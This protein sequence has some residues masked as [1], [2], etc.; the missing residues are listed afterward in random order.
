MK[1]LIFTFGVLLF[2]GYSFF[3]MDATGL[4]SAEGLNYVP[5]YTSPSPEAASL[6]K[7]ADIPVSLYTGTPQIEIPL[8][9]LK[10]GEITIPIY[11]T[12][13]ASGIKVEDYPTW[14]GVGWTLNAGGLVAR[15]VIYC[16]GDSFNEISKLPMSTDPDTEEDFDKIVNIA[17]LEEYTENEMYYYNFNGHSGSFYLKNKKPV[18]KKYDDIKIE[19]DFDDDILITT[20]E[21]TKYF[22]HK[23]K[24]NKTDFWLKKIINANNTD[25]VAFEY[26]AGDIYLIPPKNSRFYNLYFGGEQFNSSYMAPA[27]NNFTGYLLQK[28]TTSN[29]DSIVFKTKIFSEPEASFG[30]SPKALDSMIIYSSTEKTE[31]FKFNT[32][33]IETLKPYSKRLTGYP[34]LT[35]KYMNYRSY[36]DGVEKVDN[37][38]NILSYQFS[39]YGRSSDGRDSLANRF[40]FAQDFGGYY[41]GKD[42]NSDL[43]PTLDQDV[44]S[45]LSIPNYVGNPDYPYFN[46]DGIDYDNYKHEISIEGADRSSNLNY[47]RMGTIKSIKYPTGGKVEFQ[48]SQKFDINNKPTWGLN[49][50]EIK[51][52]D[53]DGEL[54]KQKNYEYFNPVQSYKAPSFYGYM[55]HYT[56]E[57]TYSYSPSNI[58]SNFPYVVCGKS[59]Y[60]EG[61]NDVCLAKRWKW[62]LEVSPVPKDDLSLNEGPL[63]GYGQV[64]E[65]ERGNGYTIYTYST[66]G[67]YDPDKETYNYYLTHITSSTAKQADKKTYDRFFTYDYF[68]TW[69][70]W[71]YGPYP[72]N[73]WKLGQLI[74]KKIYNED[75]S[76]LQKIENNYSFIE[77]DKIP[78]IKT[79]THDQDHSYLYYQFD[80]ISSWIRLD[81][82]AEFIDGINK[83]TSYTYDSYKQIAKTET[84]NSRKEQLTTLLYYPYDINTG[85]YAS[86]TALN[87][88][89]YPVEQ[90]TLVNNQVTGS[91]LT[92][93]K[94]DDGKYLPEK[95]Y[96][97]KIESPVSSSSFTAFNGTNAESIYGKNADTEFLGYDSKGNPTK[98]LTRDGIYTYYVW[99]YNNQHPIAKITS[100]K[101]SLAI[102]Q[103]QNSINAL[104]LSGND[105]KTSVDSDISA[106]QRVVKSY[107]GNA[108]MVYYYTYKPL[109]GMA[110]QTDPNGKT[111]YYE[112]DDFGRLKMVKDND[113]KIINKYDYHYKN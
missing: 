96:S 104:G 23:N 53:S 65:T 67:K 102:G 90:T 21:G 70:T 76:L 88:L 106:L 57:Y 73:S 47:M 45:D 14:V 101:A 68:L 71:P 100:S 2:M 59:T 13:Y 82:V 39:Y 41:N 29:D 87:M 97:L 51:Y 48:Y 110:S 30:F 74:E 28:I 54:L 62:L 56:G 22:F 36:L 69:N 46:Y 85:N 32:N 93:Y 109:V 6:I 95:M 42:D 44:Y 38:G 92:I 72:N 79:Y 17:T 111:T 52:F 66:D 91:S 64:K 20:K 10:C 98:I 75:S 112:Y 86:M 77:L 5:S 55:Y 11:L 37:K 84:T 24:G 83:T 43:V 27:T 40:S 94:L 34:L 4:G 16:Y 105:D 99:G 12:Y 58:F 1:R 103:I 81:S 49:I 7:Y 18:L 33:I 113:G 80:Y 63:I 31:T 107:T 26:Q 8:Y 60:G 108:D 78:E 61:L 50:N 89:D 35:A 25:S 9:T 15:K 19:L 3:P